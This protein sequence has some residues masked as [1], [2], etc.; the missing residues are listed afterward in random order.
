MSSRGLRARRAIEDSLKTAH[1]VNDAEGGYR[2]QTIE[3]VEAGL[4]KIHKSQLEE[5]AIAIKA[6]PPV[7]TPDLVKRR[8]KAAAL[9][10]DGPEGPAGV[11]G[12]WPKPKIEYGDLLAIAGFEEAQKRFDAERNAPVGRDY[13]MARLEDVL[14]WPGRYLKDHEQERLALSLWLWCVA[15][16]KVFERNISELGVARA[17]A[18][19]RRDN[20]II[21]ILRG[22]LRDGIAP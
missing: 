16:K 4:A 13:A 9:V 10:W 22:L 11:M 19:R 2:P 15:Q 14:Y 18:F 3:E 17:A 7:W 21:I 20:A 1:P 5:L 12:F 6:P 8:L